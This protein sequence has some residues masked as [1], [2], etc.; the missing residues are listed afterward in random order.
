MT[1][2]IGSL[3]PGGQLGWYVVPADELDGSLA[4]MWPDSMPAKRESWG[5]G[6]EKRTNPD[7]TV[8]RRAKYTLVASV[9]AN[10]AGLK[11]GSYGQNGGLNR[12]MT[13]Q[14]FFQ[15]HFIYDLSG[16]SMTERF[17]GYWAVDSIEASELGDG[18]SELRVTMHQTQQDW[19]YFHEPT[20]PA[21]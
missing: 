20:T 15:P 2:S 13:V 7:G 12:F 6:W 9:I 14:Y 17:A 11:A 3:A 8:E 1:T 19:T 10:A 18:T 21:T 16:L 5:M 4:W